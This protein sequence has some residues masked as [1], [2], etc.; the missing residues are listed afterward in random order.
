[1]KQSKK[2]FEFLENLAGQLRDMRVFRGWTQSDLG[3]RAG[4]VQSEISDIESGRHNPST[5]TLL[6]IVRALGFDF[7]IVME[8]RYEA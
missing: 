8:R 5:L 4:C 2:D 7:K 1:M 3:L 6:N